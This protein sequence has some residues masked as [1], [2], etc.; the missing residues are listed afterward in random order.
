MNYETKMMEIPSYLQIISFNRMNRI[1]S[2]TKSYYEYY[3]FKY[4]LPSCAI[5]KNDTTRKNNETQNKITYFKDPEHTG[6][7]V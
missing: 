4:D 3:P 2:I 7:F 1:K 6:H 5:K